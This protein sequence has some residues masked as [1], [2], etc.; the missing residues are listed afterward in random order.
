MP[1]LTNIEKVTAKASE[2]KSPSKTSKKGTLSQEAFIT[3]QNADVVT[4]H[5]HP[6]VGLGG[7]P[8]SVQ[9]DRETA[10]KKKKT[11]GGESPSK[12][13]EK[14]PEP[15]KAAPKAMTTAEWNSHARI[16]ALMSAIPQ[17]YD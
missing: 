10:L 12:K 2:A 7:N 3:I 9:P 13:V 14:S 17:D 6:V 8:G 4:E 1:K 11:E 5:Q 15:K 16:A